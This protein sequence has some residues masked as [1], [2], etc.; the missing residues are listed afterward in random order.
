MERGRRCDCVCPECHRPLQAHMGETKAWH[1]QHDI[2]DASC[3]PQPMTLLHAFVRDRLAEKREVWLPG[4]S[5]QVTTEMLGR[6]WSERVDIA[7]RMYRFSAGHAEVRVDDIQPDVV[8]TILDKWDLAVEV[9]KTHA[10]DGAKL[11]R[12]QNS[13]KD[14]VEFDVSDLPGSGITEQEL[15]L[16]LR[17]RHRWKWLS[18]SERRWAE[19]RLHAKVL[20]EQK[21]WRAD[22]GYFANA[23]PYRPAAAAKLRQAQKRLAWARQEYAKMRSSNLSKQQR[24]KLLGSMDLTERI[25][26]VCAA[27]GLEPE[28]LPVHFTQRVQ[29]GMERHPYAW[30]LPIF[31]AFGLG[32]K[33]FTSQEVLAWMALALPDCILAH[34]DERTRNGFNR[35]Q[36]AAHSFLLQLEAQ[37]LLRSDGNTRAEVR[38]FRPVFGTKSEFLEH[39]E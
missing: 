27:M 2:D 1:F 18:W 10:V 19:A 14:A 13:F 29:L 33:A 35:T 5:V 34:P 38:V 6:R 31:A 25:A 3:N 23:M 4:G 24:A 26:V 22:I 30:Q 15:E 21:D 32:S 16:A 11:A 7:D 8:F 37:A 20:W 39:L 17:E 36:A 12:L 28:R 9:R